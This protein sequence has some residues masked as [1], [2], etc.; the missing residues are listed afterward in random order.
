MAVSLSDIQEFLGLKQIA[1]VGVSRKNG[2]YSRTV[3]DNLRCAMP[4]VI[5]VNPEVDEIEGEQCFR[6]VS[7]IYPPPQGAILLVHAGAILG[8]TRECLR[9]GVKMVW[10]RQAGST[11]EAHSQAAEECRTAGVKLIEGECPLMFL[12]GGHWIHH[13]HASMRK[14]VGTYP[15]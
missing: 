7:D 12:R 9:T 10:M 13:V 2:A 14:L 8:V 11:S 3:F 4:H 1:I 6:S 15:A 5:P